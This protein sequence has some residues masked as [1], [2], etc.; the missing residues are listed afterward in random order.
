M[1]AEARRGRVGAQNGLPTSLALEA[2]SEHP[3]DATHDLA[4]ERFSLA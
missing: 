2:L 1:T 4:L 3:E